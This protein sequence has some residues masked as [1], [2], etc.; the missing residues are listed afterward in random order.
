MRSG[1]VSKMIKKL[2]SF[3]DF[4]LDSSLK[5]GG[6]SAAVILLMPC[7]VF[8]LGSSPSSQGQSPSMGSFFVPMFFIIVVFYFLVFRPQQKQ[9]KEQKGMLEALKKGEKVLTTGGIYGTVMQVKGGILEL[10]ISEGVKVELSKSAVTKVISP[11]N[12]EP[13][14]ENQRKK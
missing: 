4:Q 5:L 7:T 8:G 12:K 1:L 3:S 6:V 13:S 2:L 10:K 14:T 11:E 9:Q